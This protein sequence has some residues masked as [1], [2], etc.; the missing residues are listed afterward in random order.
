M[1]QTR[2][3]SGDARRV[4]A[5]FRDPDGNTLSLTRAVAHEHHFPGLVPVESPSHKAAAEVLI[6]EYLRWVASVAKLE[7]GL[8]FDVEAMV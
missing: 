1:S 4:V 8:E 5:W 3:E 6:A 7:Y 2:R